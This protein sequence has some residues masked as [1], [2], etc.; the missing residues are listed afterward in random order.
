LTLAQAL[1]ALKTSKP[2]VKGIVIQEQK[3]PGKSTPTTISKPQSQDKDK[4]LMI[5]EPVKPKMKD[6]IM[7]DEEAAKRL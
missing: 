4:G 7:F 5:E 2:K 6:Q 1:K 3:E